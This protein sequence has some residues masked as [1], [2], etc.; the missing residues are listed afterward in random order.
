MSVLHTIVKL[1]MELGLAVSEYNSQNTES[2][3]EI[4][5]L[6]LAYLAKVK[7]AI[8]MGKIKEE[9]LQGYFALVG[10]SWASIQMRFINEYLCEKDEE[11]TKVKRVD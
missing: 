7:E 10:Q 6:T 1:S 11:I 5:K 4:M 3:E 9:E 8:H 2:L